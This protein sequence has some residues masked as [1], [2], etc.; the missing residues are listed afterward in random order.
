MGY[1][2]LRPVRQGYGLGIISTPKGIMDIREARKQKLGGEY[3]FQI[4]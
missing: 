2:D 3:L 4:W 1:K